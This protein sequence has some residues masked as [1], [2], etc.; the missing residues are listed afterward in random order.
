MTKNIIINCRELVLVEHKSSFSVLVDIVV[1]AEYYNE[2][3][4]RKNCDT[5]QKEGFDR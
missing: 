3:Y 1:D 5:T 4:N 2:K